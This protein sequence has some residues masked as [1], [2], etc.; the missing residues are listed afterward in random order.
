[1]RL[2][3]ART[4]LWVALFAAAFAFVEASVVIY[5]RG[6]YYPEGFA[7]PLKPISPS[8][9][10]VELAR[11]CATIVML[12][13]TGALAG[14]TP[15]ERFSYFLFAF[16]LWDIL[17]Y[18]WLKLTINWPPSLTTFDILFL[19]PV[20]WI[21]PVWA[22][23]A[24]SAI[25]IVCGARCVHRI[26]SSLPFHPGPLAYL[27]GIASTALI[28]LSFMIDTDATLGG[29]APKPYLWELLVTGLIG[30]LIAYRL[31]CRERLTQP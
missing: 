1:M 20:P 14:K 15:W 6:L 7:F 3:L 16:G 25:M 21:G 22:P 31:S 29:S 28:L 5:L 23:L 11:E 26:H 2:P 30:Y 27:M 18:L 13:C 24:V 10:G 17:F 19:V 9:L 8:H 4:L 12:Y